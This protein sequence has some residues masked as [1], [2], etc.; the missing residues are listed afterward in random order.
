MERLR[1]CLEPKRCRDVGRIRRTPARAVVRID[2]SWRIV[3]Y[4]LLR[5]LLRGPLSPTSWFLAVQAIGPVHWM[6]ATKAA[7]VLG[8]GVSVL[9]VCK[10][11]QHFAYL[12]DQAD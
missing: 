11:P 8:R 9:C 4:V 10:K 12:Y 6:E 7:Y 2:L 5:A 3:F 1:L